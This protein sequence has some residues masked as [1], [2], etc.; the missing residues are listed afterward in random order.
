MWCS[1]VFSA[2]QLFPKCSLYW[3]GSHQVFLNRVM[4]KFLVEKK[5]LFDL[6]YVENPLEI[7][8]FD[9]HICSWT[10]VTFSFLYLN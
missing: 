5:I 4:I 10:T 8:V 3:A 7:S 6:F 1:T 9:L 2:G